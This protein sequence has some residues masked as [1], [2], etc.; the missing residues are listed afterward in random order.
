M[1]HSNVT[2]IYRKL[3][4]KIDAAATRAPWNAALF[5]ILKELYTPEEAEIL[6]RM[7]YGLSSAKKILEITKTDESH[8]IPV[9][10]S[11]SE[12][13]LVFDVM[14]N[15]RY[16]YM[17]APMAVGIFEMTMMRTRGE[18]SY[19]KWAELFNQYLHDSDEFYSANCKPGNK[20]SI[21]RA[22]PH[23]EA[24]DEAPDIEILDY[25]KATSIIENTD[26][27]GIGLC[28]CRHE[29]LHT[30][31]KECDTPLETCLSLGSSATSLIRHGFA[32]E[33]TRSEVLEK[34]AISKEYNLVL[35]ADNVKN[36]VG[37]ICQCCGCCCN[38]LLGISQHGFPNTIITSS[39]IAHIDDTLCTDCEKCAKTCP[40]Q[41]VELI[42]YDNHSSR[43]GKH[44]RID[45]KICLG[46]GLCA[47]SCKK[48]AIK[49]V[50]REKRVL[51]PEST[52][53]RVILASLERGTLQYQ[54]FNEPQNISHRVLRGLVGG[55][56][57]LPF[58][59]Q[60]LM[61][62][63]LRSRFLTV[64]TEAAKKRIVQE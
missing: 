6:V 32:R 58:V 51:C 36:Q 60:G 30:G 24:V 26:K 47:M 4:K 52:F 2:D 44:P 25:E 23:L 22:L 40:I 48:G 33:I 55:F 42:D 45:E 49:L 59:K 53:E 14:I 38:V 3:G 28:S 34:I 5:E 46:C 16:H 37:F 27:F 10:D 21:M 62:D 11:L 13:G 41:A 39:Y 63:T 17:I 18:L 12:K 50:K 20:V 19:K 8:L 9:L 57:R 15:G 64:L 35:S 29:K 1:G 7:P 43:K 31:T 61:S 56:L 54:L